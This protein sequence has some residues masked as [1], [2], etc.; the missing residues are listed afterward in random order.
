MRKHILLSLA[1]LLAGGA[2]GAGGR[3]AAQQR[4]S[5]RTPR[6]P[7]EAGRLRAQIAQGC[8]ARVTRAKGAW[9][10]G[11]GGESKEAGVWARRLRG[12]GEDDGVGGSRTPAV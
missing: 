7:A 6:D 12:C 5:M 11:K 3:L 10:G 9:N 2:G 8:N 4:D 1:V